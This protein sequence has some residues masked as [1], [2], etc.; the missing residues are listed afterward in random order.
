[1]YPY[2]DRSYIQCTKDNRRKKRRRELNRNIYLRFVDY[3]KAFD[4]VQREKC[5][6]FYIRKGIPRNLM[7]LLKGLHENIIEKIKMANYTRMNYQLVKMAFSEDVYYRPYSSIYMYKRDT[8]SGKSAQ[9]NAKEA[10]R[11]VGIKLVNFNM[12]TTSFFQ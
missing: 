6:K 9:T 2:W 11:L 8:H 12:Q 1:M 5:E 4:S 7:C 3:A 10:F